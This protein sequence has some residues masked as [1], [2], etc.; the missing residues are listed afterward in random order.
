MEVWLYRE[1]EPGPRGQ[2]TRRKIKKELY[3]RSSAARRESFSPFTK[4]YHGS[5]VFVE[6]T[7]NGPF[8]ETVLQHRVRGNWLRRKSQRRGE[9]FSDF[10]VRH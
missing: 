2:H 9:H 10:R 6:V 8:T 3:P 7:P 4:T 1:N 5:P